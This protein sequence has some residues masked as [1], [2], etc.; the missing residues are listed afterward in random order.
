M[1]NVLIFGEGSYIGNA[2]HSWLQNKGEYNVTTMSSREVS[3]SEIDLSP[4][5]VVYY[6]AGIAHQKETKENAHLYYEVNRD[7]ACAVAKKAKQDGVGQFILMSTLSVYGLNEGVI[8]KDTKE[9]P[10]THYGKSKMQA[11]RKIQKLAD[12]GFHV[13]IIRPPMVYGANCKGNYQRLRSLALKTP[14]FP[15]IKNRRSMI[16]IDNLCDFI[17]RVIREDIIGIRIPQNRDYVCTSE[18]VRLIAKQ[19]GKKVIF[20]KVPERL[21]KIFPV[22]TVKKVFGSLICDSREDRENVVPDFAVTIRLAEKRGQ[23]F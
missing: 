17:E 7:L 12:N 19:H 1:K 2:V 11:D 23:N 6:V 15:E 8:R 3:V 22:S 4:Y 16:Y 21:V 10:T 13:A 9:R 20:V 5:Q 18:M 14:V